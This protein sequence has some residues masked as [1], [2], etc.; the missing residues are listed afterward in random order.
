MREYVRPF[1]VAL[2]CVLALGFAAATL[3]SPVTTGGDDGTSV[4]VDEEEMTTEPTEP[5]DDPDT[6][7]Q[8]QPV[9][10]DDIAIEENL[11]CDDDTGVSP[12][13][14]LLAAA[15]FVGAVVAVHFE[16]QWAIST[17]AIAF[18]AVLMVILVSTIGCVDFTPAQETAE[19]VATETS[20]E[21]QET[22]REIGT[23]DDD[24][25]IVTTPTLLTGA[26]VVILL[27]ALLASVLRFRDG[28]DPST[29]S[30]LDHDAEEPPVRTVGRVAGDA[31]DDIEEDVSLENAV[32][33]AWAGMASALDVDH[34]ETSTP[35]EFAEAARDAGLDPG[36]VDE[37]TALFEEVRYGTAA[38]T[39]DRE[40]QAVASL[41]RL[42]RQ[43]GEEWEGAGSGDGRS[44]RR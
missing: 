21:I 15:L 41:R 43:Y 11:L 33:R 27:F 30:E 3:S 35:A 39:P 20:D 4:L 32:Y 23:G 28:E 36:D 37:L 24:G 31:A 9:F 29:P 22:T 2:L 6:V 1:T 14:L 38:P 25:L 26:V 16:V 7:S 5:A 34:P 44:G 8:E 18:G 10:T 17:V 42:E 12:W 40:R 19:Q 13:L